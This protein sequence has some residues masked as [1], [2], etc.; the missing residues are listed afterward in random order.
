MDAG[1]F[2]GPGGGFRFLGT[3][4]VLALISRIRA[5]RV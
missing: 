3:F 1:G 4:V 2:E 5:L